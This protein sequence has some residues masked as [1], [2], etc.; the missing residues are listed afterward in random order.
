MQLKSY[1]KLVFCFF[2]IHIFTACGSAN[3]SD[4]HGHKKGSVVSSDGNGYAKACEESLN[5]RLGD[6]LKV[7]ED[8]CL[9]SGKKSE[10]ITGTNKSCTK[11][12]KGQA[13]VVEILDQHFV[14]IKAGGTLT[15]KTG[16]IT[17]KI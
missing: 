17:E 5:L 9:S 3:E 14:K 15:L 2:A 1:L 6:K 13:E 11:F 8:I 7:Y 4:D 16:E 10:R 12:F